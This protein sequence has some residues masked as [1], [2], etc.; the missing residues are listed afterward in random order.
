MC[1]LAREP[2]DRVVSE[3]SIDESETRVLVRVGVRPEISV[4]SLRTRQDADRIRTE[5]TAGRRA[6]VVGMGFIGS[7]VAASLR[8]AGLDVV[9]IDPSKTP[10]F[11]VLG[12]AV[13]EAL[14]GLH[15]AHGVRTIFG[16][17][18]AAFEGTER[19]ARVVTKG[20]QH[21]E[22]DLVVTGQR[23]SG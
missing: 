17:T 9:T 16:D 20:G 10:L 12:D 13:G 1:P 3:N 11:R 15:R 8:L 4:Y 22:C 18:V 14:A 2:I 5:M 19:V 21:L 6:V 23:P 7:E